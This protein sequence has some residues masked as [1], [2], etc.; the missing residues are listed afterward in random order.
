MTNEQEQLEILNS[1]L[2]LIKQMPSSKAEDEFYSLMEKAKEAFGE[3]HIYMA[4]F[5]F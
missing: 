1:Q 5:Y 2:N 3:D 4:K